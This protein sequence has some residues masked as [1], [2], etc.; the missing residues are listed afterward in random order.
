MPAGPVLCNNVIN[1]IKNTTRTP[2]KTFVDLGSG[3]GQVVLAVAAAFP[4]ISCVGVENNAWLVLASRWR[5]RHLPN[6]SFVQNDLYRVK[7]DNYDVIFVCL[8][9]S[10]LARLEASVA[11]LNPSPL[12][13]SARFP[14]PNK[15]PS[16]I[17][18]GGPISGVWTYS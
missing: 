16:Q 8:V 3:D 11:N 18:A 15:T 13:I 7:L 17:I 5:A 10:M 12:V 1:I 14:L 4:S 2:L 9:P 6:A